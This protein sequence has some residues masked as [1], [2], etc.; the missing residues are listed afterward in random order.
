MYISIA[1]FFLVATSALTVSWIENP[2]ITSHF[3]IMI[4][5]LDTVTGHLETTIN[6]LNKT[7][8]II[9]KP[10]N[11]SGDNCGTLSGID[12]TLNSTRQVII[13]T[14][15]AASRINSSQ[16]SLTVQEE[17][18]FKDIHDTLNSGSTAINSFND[19]LEII[20]NQN[21]GLPAILFNTNN[22]IRT[23][24]GSFS[25][26]NTFMDDSDT[27][28][29]EKSMVVLSKNLASTSGHIDGISADS[30]WKLHQ[31]LHPDKVKLTFWTGTEATIRWIHNNIEPPIF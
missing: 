24:Q 3:D 28:D 20:N 7:L 1:L 10:C 17:Q 13:Q 9:N 21:A 2:N 4:E 15:I 11:S 26:I 30:Q 16:A 25:R 12:S 27:K 31:L 23:A 8:N 5:H 19:T 14:N 18:L 22:T 29:F 6:N